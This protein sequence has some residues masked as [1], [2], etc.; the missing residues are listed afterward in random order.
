MPGHLA[1]PDLSGLVPLDAVPSPPGS[2]PEET[3]CLREEPA[4]VLYNA[5]PGTGFIWK[6][7][8]IARPSNA[9]HALPIAHDAGLKFN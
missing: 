4:V 6:R 7:F 1:R 2:G 9:S 8:Q 5:G 3:N